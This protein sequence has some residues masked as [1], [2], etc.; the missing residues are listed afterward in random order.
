M[1]SGSGAAEAELGAAAST[2]SSSLRSKSCRI[3]SL[4]SAH[5]R[6]RCMRD[7][8]RYL[9]RIPIRFAARS[10]MNPIL[11]GLLSIDPS[12]TLFGL[13]TLRSGSH[14]LGLRSG[15]HLLGLRSGSHLLGLK[16]LE[17]LD[18][19]R[20]LDG[21]LGDRLW[22]EEALPERK[23]ARLAD[24]PLKVARPHVLDEQEASRASGVER[25]RQ[26]LDILL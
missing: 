2:G 24:R 4:L 25:S 14:L 16:L 15:S 22:R 19:S 12:L 17:D 9:W 18:Q 26:R 11:G 10:A 23:P 5:E 13:L 21:D 8:V 6:R 7:A 1:Y 20:Q 3:P